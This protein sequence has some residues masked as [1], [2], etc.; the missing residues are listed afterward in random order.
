MKQPHRILEYPTVYDKDFISKIGEEGM[1]KQ[2]DDQIFFESH[3]IFLTSNLYWGIGGIVVGVWLIASTE[4]NQQRI[5]P[6]LLILGGL[7]WM[8]YGLYA[9]KN[10]KIFELNR[11]TGMVT[12]PDSYFRKP[13]KGRFKELH[14]VITVTGN[15]DGYVDS[16]Y[17]KFVNTFNP[18][19]FTLLYTFYGS[20]P[21]KD[22]SFYVWYMDK[23]RPLPPGTAFDAYRE[24]DFE[25]RKKLG[26][27][28]PLYGSNIPTPE[29][30]PAQQA[31]RE[32]I[33]GW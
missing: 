6:I 33:G 21:Y 23:N 7:F 29:A 16:E 20:E 11:L 32:R 14:A 27:P 19:R 5:L 13:L 18:R 8:I 4:N 28:K 31:E 26:F 30:T 2:A 12:Y 15:I 1:L 17:L 3:R 10:Y 24:R 25:R 9:N 22:W